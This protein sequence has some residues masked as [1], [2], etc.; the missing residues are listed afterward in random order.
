MIGLVSLLALSLSA[1]QAADPPAGADPKPRTLVRAVPLGTL[2][3]PDE[4]A[5]AVLPYLECL[6]GSRGIE[7]R[8]RDGTP[9]PSAA[10]RGA[11]C[12]ALRR[13]AA[14]RADRL[15]RNRSLGT[16]SRR[17]EYVEI[18]LARVDDFVAGAATPPR[19]V[20]PAAPI[21]IVRRPNVAILDI[22]DELA[23]AIVPYSRCLH[24]S[25]GIV[26]R[27]EQGV[28]PPL[29]DVPLGGD[30]TAYRQ[31]ARVQGEQLLERQGVRS[32]DER[33]ARVE[34]VLAELDAFMS[35]VPA[36][37]TT[38]SANQASPDAQDR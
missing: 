38:L 3:I 19:D 10:P 13:E 4:V 31:R 28:V 7:F 2:N 20:S 1:T 29:P 30:C 36:P 11:D 9:Q 26:V 32:A 8:S 24:T 35:S 6:Y 18:V 34:A 25:R 17:A 27:N 21:G 22:P 5:P 12:T 15:L 37:G 23:P 33:H 16:A 14:D